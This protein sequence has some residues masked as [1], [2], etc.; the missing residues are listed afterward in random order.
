[1]FKATCIVGVADV[2]SVYKRKAA[3]TAF[4][5]RVYRLRGQSLNSTAKLTNV[6][7]FIPVL[8]TLCLQ[9]Y[10]RTQAFNIRIRV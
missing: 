4:A 7:P 5:I 6:K 2:I 3:R 10:F 8:L 1:M 9:S